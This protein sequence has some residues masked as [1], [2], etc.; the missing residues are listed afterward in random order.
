MK[1]KLLAVAAITLLTLTNLHAMEKVT[2]Q[3]NPVSIEGTMPAVGK[4]APA[5]HLANADLKDVSIAEFG[6]TRKVLNIFVSIDTPV[7]DVSV[8][9]FNEMVAKLPNTVVLGI[10]NDLPFAQKRFC[11]AANIDKVTMLSSFRSPEFARSYGVAIPN[12]ALKGLTTRAIVVLDENNK[13]IYSQ[14]SSEITEEPD[15]QK[16]LDALKAPVK[17]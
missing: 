3:G 16:V 17:F 4:T 14:R 1:T 7:C 15:Y 10:S 2:F 11:G 5:F 6:K 13:V 9:K 8:R 12:G